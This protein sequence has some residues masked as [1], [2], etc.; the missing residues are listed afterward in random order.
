MNFLGRTG[1]RVTKRAGAWRHVAAVLWGVL[2]AAVQRRYWPRTT[3]NVFA[4]R[5][6]FIGVEATQVV[7]LVAI[8]VGA[9]VV[10]QFQYWFVKFGQMH[11]LGP[12]LVTVV[13]RELG[14][15]LVNFIVIGRS[16]TAMATEIGNMRIHGDVRVLDTQGLDP[17]TYL[18][19]PRVAGT[20]V[21]VLCLTILFITVSFISG[22][23]SGVLFGVLAGHQEQFVPSLFKAVGRTDIFNVLIKT[24]LP[25]AVTGVI[26][27]SEGLSVSAAVTE[28]PQA[29]TRAVVRSVA[30]LCA[31]SAAV[32]VMTY[33]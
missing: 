20:A 13:V 31:I 19:L 18:V 23:I 24:L 26:C 7:A 29:A 17:F 30:A 32:S 4:R 21:S 28:V 2:V 5:L 9:T 6:L 10:V 27:C 1:A 16:G 22:Y 25:G 33:L 15:L 14:P 12:V 11:L 8:M 3:R